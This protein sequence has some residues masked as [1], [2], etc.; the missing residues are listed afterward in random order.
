MQN[1]FRL[2]RPVLS[3]RWTLAG[4]FFSSL[5]IATMWGLNIST[6]FPVLKV[7]FEDKPIQQWCAEQISEAEAKVVALEEKLPTATT[8]QAK[9]LHT[10]IESE[11]DAASFYGYLQP[12]LQLL[13]RDP[14]STIVAIVGLLVLGTFVKGVFM[15]INVMLV[16]R[17][18]QRV[19]FDI[20]QKFFHRCLKLSRA[21]IGAERASSLLSRFHADVGF[22]TLAVKKL[23]GTALREPLKMVACLIGACCISPRLLILSLVL[24]P[25]AAVTIRKL[26]GSIKRANRRS[27]EEV[28]TLFGVLTE[29]FQGIE[30]VQAFTLER[31]QRRSFFGVAKK[32]L[33]KNMRIAFYSA[34]T[35]P[36]TE[37][38]GICVLA[39]AIISGA[40]LTL[41]GAVYLGPIRMLD[42]PLDMTSML[43]FFGFLI[44][45]TEPARKLSDVFNSVQAGTAAADRL[46]PLLEQEPDIKEPHSPLEL[47]SGS[48]SLAFQ[49]ISFS[50][51]EAADTVLKGIDLEIQAGETIA[52]VGSNGCGKTTLIN[53]VPRFHDATRGS[54]K[55]QGV[56]V[57]DVRT[58]DLR[59]RIG[60]V[61][62]RTLLFDDTVYENIRLGRLEASQAEIVRAA[63]AAR[64]DGFIS[65]KLEDGYNTVIGTGG[66]N[67]S[68]GQRQRIALA[69]AIVRDPDILILDEATSQ[70][71]I[72]SEQL[73]HQA[74]E[75]F[76]KDRTVIM[77]TH[78]LSTLE[79]ADRI[80]V[81]DKGRI[82][83]VGTHH[84][85]IDRCHLYQRL[86]EVQFKR[87]G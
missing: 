23:S 86:H 76:A 79:L 55:V 9:R 35:K 62:Q 49:D 46:V 73:I 10:D 75:Q 26:A 36:I 22:F 68:G 15:F 84:E 48:P 20:R 1:F 2:V 66:S 40:Y 72:E 52:I 59:R 4:I 12:A 18:E 38:L 83:D 78:R 24:T 45:A 8:E 65:E 67:L 33:Q 31:H 16:A 81:M 41:K 34:M 25:L 32:C 21:S 56:D 80:V 57:R 71:D 14:F 87:T 39:M 77:I 51:G 29:A 54:V 61:T 53:M 11:Q 43:A 85:L 6:L 58:R 27:L 17:L 3:Y 7:A 82:A 63:K 28:S 69:R 42:R 60:M 19:T 5:V 74:L 50:Y 30:T 47:P 37:Q 64:A 13:P 44:G 70:I